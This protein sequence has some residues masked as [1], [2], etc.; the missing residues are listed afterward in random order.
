MSLTVQAN[1]MDEDIYNRFNNLM[2]HIIH[3]HIP[4]AV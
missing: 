1:A 2:N 3:L 4:E